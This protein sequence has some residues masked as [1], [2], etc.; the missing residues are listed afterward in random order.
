M[1]EPIRMFITDDNRLLREG[2]ESMLAQQQDI[3]VIGAT[4]CLNVSTP[5][6]KN[7]ASPT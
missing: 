7:S 2:L 4:D 5:T 1:N 6:T 3:I